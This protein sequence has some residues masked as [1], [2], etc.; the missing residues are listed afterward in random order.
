VSSAIDASN[1]NG[2]RKRTV[3]CDE[4]DRA[5]VRYL[6]RSDDRTGG[7]REQV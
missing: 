4:S 5:I 1:G 7:G 3:D 2:E 6:A